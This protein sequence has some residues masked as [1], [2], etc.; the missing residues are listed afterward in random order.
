MQELILNL[1]KES[2]AT[3]KRNRSRDL[4]ISKMGLFPKKSRVTP[5]GTTIKTPLYF[6]ENVNS[7]F[8]A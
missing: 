6:L 2:D 3:L 4:E 8:E 1:C 5:L 7:I